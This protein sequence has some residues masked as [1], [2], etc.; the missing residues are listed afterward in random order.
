M[1]DSQPVPVRPHPRST[2][3]PQGVFWVS[4]LLFLACLAGL[5]ARMSAGEDPALRATHAA[6]LPAPRRVLIRRVVERRVVVHLPPSERAPTSTASQQVG[7]AG[8]FS[9]G[10]PLTH[11]S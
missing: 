3:G 7:T 5:A 4:S 8:A 10:G 1:T 6:A 11:A 2:R 9:S